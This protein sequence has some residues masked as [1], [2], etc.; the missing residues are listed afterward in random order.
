LKEK[1]KLGLLP[2]ERREPEAVS[3]SGRNQTKFALELPAE[4]P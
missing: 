3:S 1:S 4:T 2:T